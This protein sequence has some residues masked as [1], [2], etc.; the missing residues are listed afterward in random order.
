M[1]NDTLHW[2]V[3]NGSMHL[4]TGAYDRMPAMFFEVAGITVLLWL[5][6]LVAFAIAFLTSMVGVSGAFLLCPSR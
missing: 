2:R 6:P 5:P 3:L 4:F 1:R